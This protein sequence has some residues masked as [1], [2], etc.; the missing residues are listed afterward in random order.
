M[1]LPSL[2]GDDDR[3]LLTRLASCSP[4]GNVVELGVYQGGSAQALYQVCEQQH[5]TLYLYD[6]FSGHPEIDDALDVRT[7]HWPG[8]YHD[9]I[10]P[11]RLQALL[12]NAVII[13]GEFP[14]SLRHDMGP[15]AFVHSDMDLYA[16]TA[17]VCRLLP[18]L[19]VEGGRLWFDDYGRTEC[20]GVTRAVDDALFQHRAMIGGKPLITISRSG[21]MCQN[22]TGPS[23][24]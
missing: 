10:S 20:P 24:T 5:R 3:F 4:P 23:L 7:A 2:L 13:Q 19:M 17:A 9:A 6:T 11:A 15:I 16:P 18:P 22:E 1:T 14:H 12:P 21:A 8:R